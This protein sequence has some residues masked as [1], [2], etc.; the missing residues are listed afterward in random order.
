MAVLKA[1]RLGGLPYTLMDVLGGRPCDSR[2][3]ETLWRI[4]MA[5]VPDNTVPNFVPGEM[6][7][8]LQLIADAMPEMPGLIAD[9]TPE[10]PERI[11]DA[12]PEMPELIAD[13]M[14]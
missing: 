13:A 7:E 10:M 3:Q 9:A 8:M 2:V 12:M 11:A 14:P 4:W 5:R 1:V 6:P